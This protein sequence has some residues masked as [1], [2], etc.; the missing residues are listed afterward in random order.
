MWVEGNS[1]WGQF[2]ISV[3]LLMGE[4]PKSY[5][6]GT[7]STGLCF[8]ARPV[9]AC[10]CLFLPPILTHSSPVHSSSRQ[11]HSAEC[12]AATPTNLSLSPNPKEKVKEMVSKAACSAPTLC[13]LPVWCSKKCHFQCYIK[14][15][16]E[17]SPLF[18]VLSCLLGFWKGARQPGRS[19]SYL[20]W[21]FSALGWV[22]GN[23]CVPEWFSLL[24]FMCSHFEQAAQNMDLKYS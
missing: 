10:S 5:Y 2:Q 19:W 4:F 18:A 16:D 24:L 21:A 9:H 15:Q 8:Q 1:L 17:L 6:L 7:L 11:V 23:C 20:L 3:G 12:L 13:F 14:V 22:W